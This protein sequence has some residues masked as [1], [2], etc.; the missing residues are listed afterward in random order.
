MNW[1]KS[2]GESAFTLNTE[3]SVGLSGFRICIG[4][5]NGGL[6]LELGMRAQVSDAQAIAFS[7]PHQATALLLDAIRSVSLN[8]KML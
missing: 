5:Q 7:F 3:H 6:E 2:R 8:L 4:I 1:T